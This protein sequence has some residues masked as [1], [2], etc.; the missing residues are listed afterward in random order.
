MPRSLDWRVAWTEAAAVLLSSTV[1]EHAFLSLS[2]LLDNAHNLSLVVGWSKGL[3]A[4]CIVHFAL[5]QAAGCV[6]LLVPPLYHAI[7]ST[8][9]AAVLVGGVWSEALFLG[10]MTQPLFALRSVC[11]ALSTTCLG[12]FRV[13]HAARNARLQV[14]VNDWMLSVETKTRHAC[15]RAMCGAHCP[16][17]G[18][19]LLVWAWRRCTFWTAGG[20]VREYQRARFQS[21]VAVASLLFCLAAQDSRANARAWSLCRR[22]EEALAVS[23]LGWR[24]ALGRPKQL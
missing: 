19:A 17:L 12:V 18:T 4:V 10:D 9:P 15:T 6:A 14:P 16:L 8:I 13:D 23:G 2:N 1:V 21:A 11:I 5:F 22:L 24:G 3:C 20:V 7:G